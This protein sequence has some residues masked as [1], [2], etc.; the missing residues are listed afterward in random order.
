MLDGGVE[1]RQVWI[2][3]SVVLGGAVMLTLR[4]IAALGVPKIS[5]DVWA[6][7]ANSRMPGNAHPA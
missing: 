5:A 2:I 6:P 3:R 1:P 7:G 4:G